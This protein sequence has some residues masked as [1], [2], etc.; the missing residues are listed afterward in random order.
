MWLDLWGSMFSL[1]RNGGELDDAYKQ[2]LLGASPGQSVLYLKRHVDTTSLKARIQLNTGYL[3]TLE[4]GTSRVAFDDQITAYF[5]AGI[6]TDIWTTDP[7]PGKY[8]SPQKYDWGGP[9]AEAGIIIWMPVAYNANIET[10]LLQILQSSLA[11]GIN[12]DINW[13]AT[14]PGGP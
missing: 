9:Y 4:F 1:P 8:V 10:L 2:R 5:D 11:A 3:P 6:P 14:V 12:V 13:D 7:D